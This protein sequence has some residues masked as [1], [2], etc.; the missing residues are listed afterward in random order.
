MKDWKPQDPP[1]SLD[2]DR[3][4]GPAPKL[5]YSPNIGH[6]AWRLE[7]AYGNGHL[8]DWGIHLIDQARRI[9]GESFPRRIQAG[10]GNYVFKEEITTPDTLSAHF[11]FAKCPVVWRHRIW[12]S[13]EEDPEFQNGIFFYGRKETVFATDDRW[14]VIPC[15]RKAERR[16]IRPDGDNDMPV[17]HVADFLQAVRSRKAPSCPIEE[18]YAST[19]TVQLG[20]IAYRTGARIEWD[21]TRE[22]IVGNAEAARM[23]RREYRAPY[24]HPSPT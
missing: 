5:P 12:G 24:V 17:K 13:A 2:W 3:W 6:F 20:M 21:A 7:A 22:Q 18:G 8:V 10:G 19:A 15:D 11:E 16:V 9:L 1:A 23:L 14:V 4:C